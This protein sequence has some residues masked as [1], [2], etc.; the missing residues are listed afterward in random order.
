MR[1]PGFDIRH[2]SFTRGVRGYDE[3]EVL[4]ALESIAPAYE[5]AHATR[6]ELERALTEAHAERERLLE[7]ERSVIRLIRAAEEDAR[8]RVASAQREVA[9]LLEHAEQD[10]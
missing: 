6:L 10:A 4:G 5:E 9:R 7:S 1:Q 8:I 2:H 3:S